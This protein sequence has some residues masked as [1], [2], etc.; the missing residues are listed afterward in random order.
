MPSFD[1]HWKWARNRCYGDQKITRRILYPPCRH[2]GDTQKIRDAYYIRSLPD[3]GRCLNAPT[4]I[5]RRAQ[6]RIFQ[7]SFISYYFLHKKRPRAARIFFQISSMSY[8]F[9]NEK[10]RAKRGNSC[11]RCSKLGPMLRASVLLIPSAQKILKKLSRNAQNDA[12][13]LSDA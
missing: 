2:V 11:A 10:G 13:K 1:A 7:I 5:L 12:Q 3:Y 8:H 4:P 6:R 9:I